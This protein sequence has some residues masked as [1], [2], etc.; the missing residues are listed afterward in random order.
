MAFEGSLIQTI[1]SGVNGVLLVEN[2]VYLLADGRTVSRTTY[3]DLYAVISG[4]YG[5]SGD[6]FALPDVRGYYLRGDSLD[7]ARDPDLASRTLYGP[8]ATISGVGT[9]QPSAGIDHTH[10]IS[11]AFPTQ[12]A[13]NSPASP[14]S[15]RSIVSS[16]ATVTSSGIES[17]QFFAPPTTST[18]GIDITDQSFMNPSSYTFYTYIKAT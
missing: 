3:P 4:R 1:A 11:A 15:F 16:G 2:V 9:F 12:P 8:N 10:T 13:D 17:D 7:S 5:E 18:S 6:L 14:A